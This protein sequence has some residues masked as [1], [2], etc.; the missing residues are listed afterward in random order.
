MADLKSAVVKPIQSDSNLCVL[1]GYCFV[2]Q[3]PIAW[4]L[5][6]QRIRALYCCVFVHLIR[7]L[8][9]FLYAYC[10]LYRSFGLKRNAKI[11]ELCFIFTRAQTNILGHV[12]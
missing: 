3:R 10:R 9:S 1:Q 12:T 8:G 7:M 11:Q 2:W 4:F 6:T 5:R